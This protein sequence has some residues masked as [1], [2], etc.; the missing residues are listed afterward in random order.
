[1]NAQA[2]F[3]SAEDYSGDWFRSRNRQGHWLETVIPT[4]AE[5]RLISRSGGAAAPEVVSSIEAP[6]AD[7]YVRTGDGRLWHGK[8]VHTG[9]KRKLEPANG[10]LPSLIPEAG[11]RLRGFLR[12]T[13]GRKNY[14]YG[15]TENAA[16]FQ[17]T[18]RTI[19]WKS[20]R[21]VYLG[22]VTEATP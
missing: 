2:L 8:D 20:Q 14:F 7:L 19:G 18:L 6:L 9:E 16:A 1:M 4:R 10:G 11:E 15:T 21:A 3:N 17:P 5:V 13:Q 22:P 12:E